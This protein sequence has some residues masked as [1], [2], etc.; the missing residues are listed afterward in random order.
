MAEDQG[1]NGDA[2]T[3]QACRLFEASGWHKI[4]ASNLDIKDTGGKSKGLDAIFS[5]KDGLLSSTNR[6]VFVE[7]KSWATTSLSEKTLHG[8]IEGLTGKVSALRN[9]PGLLDT[10]QETQELE[11]STG[12][13]ACYFHDTEKYPEFAATFKKWMSAV[14]VPYGHADRPFHPRVFVLENYRLLWL[15]SILSSVKGWVAAAKEGERREL[16]FFYPSSTLQ[17]NPV[18]DSLSMNIEY[19]F[20]GIVLAQGTS[21]IA[22]TDEFR[23]FNFA[24]YS[25]PLDAKGFQ[26]LASALQTA[27]MIDNRNQ[28]LIYKYRRE[29]EEFRKIK[30]DVEKMLRD[31]GP[32]DVRIN[33]M[34]ST[35]V[36]PA[37]VLN[38][39]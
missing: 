2:W 17:G 4:A 22:A 13:I 30:P 3:D 37:W 25:G 5:Y 39:E 15:A 28:L 14:K 31:L 16:R 19:M 10:Y 7:A 33:D 34:D 32:K 12:V 8:W 1:V 21:K 27:N 36:M 20:S 6:G 38:G 35:A 24:F 11:I 9:S 26:R 18:S 29:N 23:V